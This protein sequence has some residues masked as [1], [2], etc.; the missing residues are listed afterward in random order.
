MTDQKIF[1]WNEST[2]AV[3]RALAKQGKEILDDLYDLYGNNI[4]SEELSEEFYDKINKWK[5]KC[6]L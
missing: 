3:R 6:E 5:R 2:D 1:S 4:M